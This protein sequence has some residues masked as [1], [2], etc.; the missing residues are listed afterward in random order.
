MTANTAKLGSLISFGAGEH[1][2][3]T[4]KQATKLI[5]LSLT[6]LLVFIPGAQLFSY[7]L[8]SKWVREEWRWRWT[9]A[10]L[11][12]PI[13]LICFKVGSTNVLLYSFFSQTGNPLIK[14]ESK[15][16]WD[17]HQDHCL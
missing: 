11:F 2:K 15:D 14:P 5:V 9:L 17:E 16:G 10:C 13:T 12:F 7:S 4:E 6:L 8:K 3:K 1:R